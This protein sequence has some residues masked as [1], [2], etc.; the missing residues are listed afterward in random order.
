[1]IRQMLKLAVEAAKVE[2]ARL[3]DAIDAADAAEMAPPAPATAAPPSKWSSPAYHI[4]ALGSSVCP[5]CEAPK[6]VGAYRCKPCHVKA[7]LV[8]SVA[9]EPKPFRN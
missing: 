7:V 2:L 1:M 9:E 5:D 4:E 3:F 6:N 8:R